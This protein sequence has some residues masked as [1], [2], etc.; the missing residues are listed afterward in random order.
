[1]ELSRRASKNVA[2]QRSCGAENFLKSIAK[3]DKKRPQESNAEKEQRSA[4]A[5]IFS[6]AAVKA[7]LSAAKRSFYGE[8]ASTTQSVVDSGA[9]KFKL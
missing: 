1:M 4:H 6:Q 9:G 7:E 2:L 8:L 5:G 3:S